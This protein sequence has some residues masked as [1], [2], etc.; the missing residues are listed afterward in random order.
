[1][2][3][4]RFV[5]NM[6][7]DAEMASDDEED[8]GMTSEQ[9]AQMNTS[10]PIARA[11]LKDIKPSLSDDAIADSLWHYYFDVDKA[12]GWLRKE[13]ERKGESTPSYLLPAPPATST[14]PSR[15]RPA[16]RDPSPEP[17]VSALQ[18]LSLAR[19]EAARSSSPA[20]ASTPLVES[21]S[22]PA[23]PMSKLA[24]LALKRKEAALNKDGASTPLA[25]APSPIST[26]P[27]EAEPSSPIPSKPLSKLAQ[28]MA[29]ARAARAETP[30]VDSGGTKARQMSTDDEAE[31]AFVETPVPDDS[32]LF[33]TTLARQSTPTAFFHLLTSTKTTAHLPTSTSTIPPNIHL[34]MVRNPDEVE[35]RIKDAFGEGVESPDDIVLKKREGRAGTGTLNPTALKI[36]KPKKAEPGVEAVT[37]EPDVVSN[38]TVPASKSKKHAMVVK[39]K[40]VMKETVQGKEVPKP[41][42]VDVQ[43]KKAAPDLRQ[44]KIEPTAK[45]KKFAV[46]KPKRAEPATKSKKTEMEKG[47]KAET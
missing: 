43:V 27:N 1:M 25:T 14:R 26:P 41:F 35:Q 47:R 16:L 22:T 29:A 18:R 45:S 21:P 19:K 6:D 28:K 8:S 15:K 9:A 20:S 17:P 32:L 3:R 34:P 4:H 38:T 5:R 33:P 39:P 44:K 36:V 13:W 2:S 42:D 11:L 24:L 7:L 30:K 23:K 12:V 46:E 40:K 37:E 10:L 31:L